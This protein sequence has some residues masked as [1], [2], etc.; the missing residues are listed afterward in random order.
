MSN[1]HPAR[2]RLTQERVVTAALERADREGVAALTM[3][4][5]AAELG[6]VPMAL[7]K[8]VTS[9]EDLI[10]EVVDRVFGEVEFQVT[11]GDWKGSLRQR[12]LSLRAALAR[13]PWAIGMMEGR[14]Q[15]GLASLRHHNAVMG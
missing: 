12:S 3:R 1:Q 15:Q 9:K 2:T 6:V 14:I 8:H 5:L 10:S 11:T 13:H 4:T 7:Y